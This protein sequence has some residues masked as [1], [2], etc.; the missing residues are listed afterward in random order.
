LL[1]PEHCPRTSKPEASSSDAVESKSSID[2]AAAKLPQRP[3]RH[4]HDGKHSHEHSKRTVED[5]GGDV[6]Y[7]AGWFI[8]VVYVLLPLII[9]CW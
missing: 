5:A 1:A 9:I 8:G 2:A 3:H 7:T 6:V 4:S